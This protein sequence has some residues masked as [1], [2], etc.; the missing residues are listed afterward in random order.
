VSSQLNPRVRHPIVSEAEQI[1]N[2][3][4]AVAVKKENLA[5]I[6]GYRRCVNISAL[7]GYYTAYI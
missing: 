7:L 3:A 2:P 5:V 6:S 4:L 1:L